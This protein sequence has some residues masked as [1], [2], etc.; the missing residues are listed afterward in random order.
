MITVLLATHNGADTIGRTLEAM[1]LLEAPPG[2][3]EIIVVNNAS[4]DKTQSLVREWQDRLPLTFLL[5]PRLGKSKAINMGLAQAKGELIVMTDDDV[6]PDRNWLREWHRVAGAWPALDVFGGAIVPEFGDHPP[7][8]PLPRASLTILYGQTPDRPESEIAPSDIAGANL[9]V[10]RHVFEKGLRFDESFLIGTQGLMG[11]DT[12]FVRTAFERGH[13]VGFTPA[14]RLR[15]IIHGNQTSWLWIMRRFFRY[16]S[17]VAWAEANEN[18]SAGGRGPAFPRWRV[19]QVAAGLLN[20]GEAAVRLDRKK[21]FEE[22]RQQAYHL[23]AIKQALILRRQKRK[24]R[25]QN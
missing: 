1:S 15:H 19:R 7:R 4:T 22:T 8:W 5:E 9:A 2:G 24:L 18:Q 23:G 16:G 25:P 14:A 11:E 17:A 12:N 10:R 20:F 6:L 3:W 13:R 21:M